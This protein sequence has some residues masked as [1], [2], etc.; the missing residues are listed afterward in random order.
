Q[1]TNQALKWYR[2]FSNAYWLGAA[3]LD[4]LQTAVRYT[5]STLGLSRP[6]QM[7]Q[8]ELISWFHTSFIKRLGHYLIELNSGRLRVGAQKYRELKRASSSD[9]TVMQP[10]E[11]A[12]IEHVGQVTLTVMG[13]VKMGKSS[14]INALLGE[15]RA[16]TDVLPAT[17][18]ITRYE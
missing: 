17:S 13:Q 12:P 15:Q 8:Q 2:T 10:P 6:W 18:E 7:F 5:A 9:G 14:L 4:P 3:F 11:E 1:Y 16:K